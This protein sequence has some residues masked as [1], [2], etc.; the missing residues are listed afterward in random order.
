MYVDIS[1]EICPDGQIKFVIAMKW[2]GVQFEHL[3]F[4]TSIYFEDDLCYIL[5]MKV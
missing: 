2:K 1:Q 3:F 5:F 4:A